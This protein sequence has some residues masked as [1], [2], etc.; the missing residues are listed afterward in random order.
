M[1]AAATSPPADDE[2][3]SDSDRSN[4]RSSCSSRVNDRR[5]RSNDDRPTNSYRSASSSLV[6]SAS[7]D[8]PRP[9]GAAQP[10]C[11]CEVQQ[12]KK[13]TVHR[14]ILQGKTHTLQR[15]VQRKKEKVHHDAKAAQSGDVSRQMHEASS[16]AATPHVPSQAAGW[17]ADLGFP[18]RAVADDDDDCRSIR[19]DFSVRTAVVA[20]CSQQPQDAAGVKLAL[21]DF[22]KSLVR[23]R[24]FTLQPIGGFPPRLL[25]CRLE[26]DMSALLVGQLGNSQRLTLADVAQ[27]HRG[28][29]A[30]MLD[31]DFPL[32]SNMAVFELLSGHCITF[33]L[34]HT[35]LADEFVLFLR[36]LCAIQRQKRQQMQPLASLGSELNGVLA[37]G[38]G[39][40]STQSSVPIIPAVRS[41]NDDAQSECSVQT[42]MCQRALNSTPVASVQDP[43]QVKQMFKM[44]TE[45]MRRGRDFY[46]V[47]EGSSLQDVECKLT[48]GHDEFR[49]MWEFQDRIIPLTEIVHVHQAA[50]ARKL[51]LEFPVDERCATM[52]LQ[53]G[54]CITFKFG[55]VEAC[56]RF[57]LCMRILID[58]KSQRFVSSGIGDHPAS[59]RRVVSASS[60]MP[61]SRLKSK[62]GSSIG[63]AKAE[64]E[65]FVKQ[66]LSGCNLNVV[67]PAG[68]V[69]VRCTMDV[70]LKAINFLAH[71]GSGREV[72]LKDVKAIHCGS[73]ATKLGFK[74]A[75]IENL[76]ATVELASGDCV[77]FKFPDATSLERFA[78]CMRIFAIAQRQ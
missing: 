1:G 77:T 19:S 28:M 47:G 15:Q 67:G 56:D 32:D 4:S 74:G 29:E 17:P 14:H 58:K 44:F 6:S 72:K 50:D 43:K 30:V 18:P 2:S 27:L 48:K 34:L 25:P 69:S 11:C 45:T 60:A 23:G 10:C 20:Q 71:D 35:Q 16:V 70:N 7:H 9:T 42:G 33:H 61:S 59:V 57:R 66:M 3:S 13:E 51:R 21:R 68:L 39:I 78:G 53:S 26:K 37:S 24:E 52:E 22:V 65:A 64:V 49:M 46:V 8:H 36:I 55:H 76:C 54:E 62:D 12:G 41:A 5:E 73:E 63:A 40:A 75:A 38:V 31:L